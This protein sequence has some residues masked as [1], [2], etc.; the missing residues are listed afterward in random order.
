[1]NRRI[2]QLVPT[3]FATI[4]R[5]HFP[6][7]PDDHPDQGHPE[8]VRWWMWLGRSYRINRTVI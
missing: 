6:D 3:K 7:L 2:R 4:S 5:P 1:M 8:F